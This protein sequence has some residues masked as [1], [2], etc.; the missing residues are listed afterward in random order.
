[1]TD[2]D[3]AA[4][5]LDCRALIS[6]LRHTIAA[7]QERIQTLELLLRLRTIVEP[8]GEDPDPIF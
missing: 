5:C 8:P 2:P 4:H 3:C 1:M 7:L 6:E